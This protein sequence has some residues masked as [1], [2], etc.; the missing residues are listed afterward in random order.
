MLSL[1]NRISKVI[2]LAGT[3]FFGRRNHGN[4]NVYVHTVIQEIRDMPGSER[5]NIKRRQPVVVHARVKEVAVVRVKNEVRA[6]G[7]SR[8]DGM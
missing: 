7:R 5:Y 1:A 6:R 2:C 4:R 8:S 3:E